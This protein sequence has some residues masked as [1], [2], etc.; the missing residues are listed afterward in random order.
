LVLE[1]AL[2]YFDLH[3]SPEHIDV[4]VIRT[5]YYAVRTICNCYSKESGSLM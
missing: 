2:D 5:D 3:W 4:L 1:L